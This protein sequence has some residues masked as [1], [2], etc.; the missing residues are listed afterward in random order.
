VHP[1]LT[2]GAFGDWGRQPVVIGVGVGADEKA[3]VLQPEAGLGESEV[4][5]SQPVPA[6]DPGVEEDDA[7]F[8]S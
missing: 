7:T 8:R 4:E 5:L 1:Q 2:S 6:A 3:D